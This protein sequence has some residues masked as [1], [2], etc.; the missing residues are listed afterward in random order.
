MCKEYKMKPLDSIW[1]SPGLEVLF[2]GFLPFYLLSGFDL[3]HQLIWVNIYTQTLYGHCPPKI[4]R[5]PSIKVK[6]NDPA[7]CNYYIEQVLE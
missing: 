3:D 4:Y 2:C 5:A 6:S 7:N 1:T